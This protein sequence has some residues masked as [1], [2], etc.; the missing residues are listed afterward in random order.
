MSGSSGYI[1]RRTILGSMAAA[2]SAAVTSRRARA[3][4][5][6]PPSLPYDVEPRGTIGIQERLPKLDLES[7][8]E[9]LTGF[10]AWAQGPLGRAA[11]ERANAIFKAEGIDPDGDVPLERIQE[12]LAGDPVVGA[13][14]R[15]WITGQQ[16]CWKML[17]DEFHANAEAYMAELAAA[18]KAGP[19]SV[20]LDP[21]FKVPAYASHEIHIQPGGYV[22]DPFA[23]YIYHY[24]TNHFRLGGND[25]D[26]RQKLV[27][28]ILEPPEDGRL[29]RILDLGCG[30]GRLTVALKD[31]F[32]NAEVWGVDVS[33]PM[34]RYAHMRAADMGRDVHFVQAL[35]EQ[36]GFPDG[37]F[38]AV[39]AYILFH[40]VPASATHAIVKEVH[41]ITRPGGVFQPIDFPSDQQRPPN[42]Y[43]RF[44]RWW[45]LRWNNEVWRDE[46]QALDFSTEIANTGF[47]V[48]DSKKGLGFLGSIHATR[49][50]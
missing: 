36:T 44:R 33:G 46:F 17:Q 8:H 48:R 50:A 1:N 49:N 5:D 37:H 42:P 13:S 25:Q 7:R 31:R 45:D 6:R 41:R 11:Q 35:A 15:Y 28:S 23:G 14:V 22:G 29:L 40:E 9:F 34:V 27:A 20:T 2:F 39:I 32:P 21:D 24:G 38:D 4:G 26:Q 10:R 19:G 3:S 30:P 43:R 16:Q 12:V 47:A 18:D